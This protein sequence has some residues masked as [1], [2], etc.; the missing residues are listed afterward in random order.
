M[1]KLKNKKQILFYFVI[2]LFPFFLLLI[3]ELSLRL[4]SY[5]DDLRLF[6]TASDPRYF[7]INRHVGERFFSKFEKTVP[8]PLS[9]YFLKEKPAGDYRIFV[10]GE[11]SVQGFPYDANLTFARI[12]QS[13]L[14]DIFP[15][16]TIRVVNLGMTAINSYAL[17]DFAD[18]ILEQKPDAI[19]IYTGH[20]EYYGALGVA[21]MENGSVP[22]WMKKLRLELV[23]L[24]TYQLIETGL[25]DILRMIHP[26]TN[27]EEKATLMEK[28]VGKDL[29]PYDSKMYSEGLRQ[30]SDNMAALLLKFKNAGVQVITSD[31]VSNVRDLPPF[32]SMRFGIYPPADS[33]YQDAER[34]EADGFSDKAK[35]EYL[36]AKDLD[37]IRFRAPEDF[38]DIIAHLADSM[39]IYRVSLKS[40]FEDHSLYGVVGDNLMTD[41]LHPN[42]DGQFLM[43][44]GFLEALRS[45]GMI[46]EKWDTSKIKPCAYYRNNWG[47][48]ELDSMIAVLRIKHLKAGWP[49]QPETAVNNFRSTYTPRGIVDSLAFMTI[50]YADFNSIMAHKKLAAYYENK[51]NFRQASKE[52]LAIAY[53]SP[54]DVSSFYYAA[55]LAA[56][57]RDSTDAIRYLEE[58]PGSDTSS[59]AQFTLAATYSSRGNYDEALSCIRRLESLHLDKRTLLQVEKLKFNVQKNSALNVDAEKTLAVIKRMDPSFSEAN[60]R[61][62]QIILIPEKIRPYIDRA[63]ALMKAGQASQALDVLKE[64]NSIHEIPYAD[65]LIGKILFAEK[66]VEALPYLEKARVELK[67]DPSLIYRLCVLYV[68]KGD[69]AKARIAMSDFGKLQG[70]NDPQ[71]REL[72]TIFEER[73]SE[74]K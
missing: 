49:F 73:V 70:E 2:I 11:S 1:P 15:D 6:S 65:L 67:G 56:R 54:L 10:L 41:H 28:M 58:S 64:S 18:E 9:Q 12:L 45:H 74:K 30:F 19:L 29:V 72:K 40:I 42:I 55:D 3:L 22:V 61:E 16:R 26:P 44:D 4:F 14:Q 43:A 13:R 63:E 62:N 38:N 68:I 5:G 57:G 71:Y 7:E 66:N 24:R 8:T 32:R 27:D 39:G 69:L 48:T 52:Y 17:L 46:E 34:L 21:S 51:G 33:L 31:L 20:N 60:G 35:E 37:V 47:Y 36:Q 25:V 23:H 53:S 59:Y 50:Q